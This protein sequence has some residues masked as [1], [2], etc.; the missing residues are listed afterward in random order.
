MNTSLLSPFSKIIGLL[1]G[2]LVLLTTGCS[3]EQ[4]SDYQSKLEKAQKRIAQLELKKTD[5]DTKLGI[6]LAEG[7]RAS[8][9]IANTQRE[10]QHARALL[11]DARADIEG[12]SFRLNEISEQ[13]LTESTALKD[14][15]A[16]ALAKNGTLQSSLATE[17]TENHRLQGQLKRLNGSL[18]DA[19]NKARALSLDNSEID[20]LKS[21]LSEVKTQA[22]SASARFQRQTRR[23]QQERDSIYWELDETKG[24]LLASEK[25]HA[26]LSSKLQITTND[27]A[28][29]RVDLA[30]TRVKADK[31]QGQLHGVI[32]LSR[33]QQQKLVG[34]VQ[35]KTLYG[36]I[37]LRQLGRTSSH[38]DRQ[39]GKSKALQETLSNQGISLAQAL[40]NTKACKTQSIELKNA[41]GKLQAAQQ[42][43]ENK[44]TSLT[45]K[46]AQE[47][48]I[49]DSLIVRSRQ[50]L[51]ND[52]ALQEQIAALNNERLAQANTI[53]K[54]SKNQEERHRLQTP[55]STHQ[56]LAP[57]EQNRLSLK[58]RRI[59]R[60]QNSL[61]SSLDEALQTQEEIRFKNIDLS[62][63]LE[64]ANAQKLALETAIDEKREQL[65]AIESQLLSSETKNASAQSYINKLTALRDELR[66]QLAEN[67][68][69]AAQERQRIRTQLNQVRSEKNATQWQTQQ[70][71][72]E[73]EKSRS[74]K[75]VLQ[76]EL[77][78]A[79]DKE[80]ALQSQIH[81]IKTHIEQ[82][83]EK[84]EALQNTLRQTR[85]MA[86]LTVEELEQIRL[87]LRGAREA[88][89]KQII[90]TKALAD[91]FASQPTPPTPSA[92]TQSVPALPQSPR[93]LSSLKILINRLRSQ[94]AA[95]ENAA[96][97]ERQRLIS[98]LNTLRNERDRLLWQ[99][100]NEE[101][102]TLYDE[103]AAL[104]SSLLKAKEEQR[105]L[106]IHFKETTQTL[107]SNRRIAQEETQAANATARRIQQRLKRLQR[108]IAENEYT[109]SEREAEIKAKVSTLTQALQAEK[110]RSRTASGRLNQLLEKTTRLRLS[111]NQTKAALEE[112]QTKT[113]A[114]ES[115]L[116]TAQQAIESMS[117][118]ISTL[119]ASREEARREAETRAQQLKISQRRVSELLEKV[120]VLPLHQITQ[121]PLSPQ[122]TGGS[123][124]Q[125][126]VQFG[127][128]LSDIARAQLGSK[129]RWSE[130]YQMNKERISNPNRIEAG[131]ELLLPAR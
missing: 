9:L 21:T 43:M 41:H 92:S 26:K 27:I 90:R 108:R 2:L 81:Q 103:N 123:Q 83:Q 115:S 10:R 18:Q 4:L 91:N 87:A 72:N 38:L 20:A 42:T 130:I 116:D 34:E 107:E 95:N 77:R 49:R 28:A 96:G 48:R 31:L 111:L 94:L 110:D 53:E 58:L 88:F 86:N 37:L 114:I 85:R 64:E 124:T 122:A 46:L 84:I 3:D 33:H 23:L 69:Q 40:E 76:R 120:T 104:S 54:I 35:E 6:A 15:L 71:L 24:Q 109:K 29:L 125:Y 17:K 118:Q 98:Q 8:S 32:L 75:A 16:Q 128:T 101:P 62:T 100:K 89:T 117:Q 119:T 39:K 70:T 56:P 51:S 131:L 1:I 80:S 11:A 36:E 57:I 61:A 5:L 45:Q 74:E 59:K 44:I 19:Q 99:Q 73:L 97:A 126:T 14:A 7:Q 78:A 113:Q 55:L 13:N 65:M 50:L 12:L 121:S 129:N 112:S 68:R 105:A 66:G 47:G 82:Q 93:E 67:E 102:H 60:E 127:E 25:E 22:A 52:G 79:K 30:N 106:R 63:Q